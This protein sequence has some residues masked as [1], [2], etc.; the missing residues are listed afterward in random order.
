MKLVSGGELRGVLF[1]A[2][3]LTTEFLIT[4]LAVGG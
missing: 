2:C 4:Q 1:D 3:L